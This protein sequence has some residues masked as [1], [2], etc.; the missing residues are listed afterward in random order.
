MEYNLLNVL[1]IEDDYLDIMNFEREFKKI[2]SKFSLHIA[3]N[4]KMAWNML[5]GEQGLEKLDPTPLIIV[6]DINMPKMNGVEFLKLLRAD[7]EFDKVKVF[8]T[9]T[10]NEEGD[11]L[12]AQALGA[13]GYIVKPLTFE[14]YQGN[15]SS[16]DAFSLFIELLK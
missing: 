5:K 4:G 14:K 12:M 8:M 15:T 1:L 10:S 16:I 2:K 11:R 3:K 13:S 7:S 6:L 9:T